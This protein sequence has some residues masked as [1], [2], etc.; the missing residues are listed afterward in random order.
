MY[1]ILEGK[2][3]E[4]FRII[5]STVLSMELVLTLFFLNSH[6]EGREGYGGRK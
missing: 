1:R 6:F 5:F 4:S 2:P 3:L